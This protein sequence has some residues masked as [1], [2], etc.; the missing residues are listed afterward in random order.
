[1][2]FEVSRL[3]GSASLNGSAWLNGSASSSCVVEMPRLG[4]FRRYIEVV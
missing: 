1:M 2:C 4:N 3:C